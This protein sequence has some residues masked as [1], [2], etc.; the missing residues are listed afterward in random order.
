MRRDYFRKMA[1]RM[2]MT[3]MTESPKIH[4]AVSEKK[5]HN[6]LTPAYQGE[7]P[8]VFGVGKESH[9]D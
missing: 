9:K 8:Q 3:G 4:N 2:F 6:F 1:V 7:A 5:R